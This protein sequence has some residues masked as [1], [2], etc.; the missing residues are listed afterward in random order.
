MA[1]L[2]DM[3]HGYILFFGLPLAFLAV[4]FRVYRPGSKRRYREDGEIPFHE[5][6]VRHRPG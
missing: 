3:L 5:D 6:D 4:V 1:H 2:L